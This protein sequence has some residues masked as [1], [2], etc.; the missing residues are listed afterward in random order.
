MKRKK[1]PGLHKG[2]APIYSAPR[3]R[4]TAFLNGHVAQGPTVDRFAIDFTDLPTSDW[5]NVAIDVFTA[6]FIDSESNDYTD[7]DQ[8]S[9]GFS[10]HLRQLYNQYRAFNENE[11]S[12]GVIE[13]SPH[14]IGLAR[15]ARR[16]AVINDFFAQNFKDFANINS[17]SDTEG[18]WFRKNISTILEWQLLIVYGTRFPWKL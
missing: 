18:H 5:N 4:I 15:L 9:K 10:S 2:K 13:G 1:T 6:A 14:A 7:V 17:S 8:V 11:A 12:G 16:R 3:S